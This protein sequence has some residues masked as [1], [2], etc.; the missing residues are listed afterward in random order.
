VVVTSCIS[1]NWNLKIDDKII[2][3]IFGSINNAYHSVDSCCGSLP[4]SGNLQLQFNIAG[5]LLLKRKILILSSKFL[6]WLVIFLKYKI[7]CRGIR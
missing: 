2:K 5:L 3:F 6:K 1:S 7:R 4:E